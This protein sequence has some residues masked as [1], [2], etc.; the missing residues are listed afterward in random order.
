MATITIPD[1]IC[2][3]CG[4]TKYTI[5]YEKR[6]TISNPDNKRVRYRCVVKA[7]ERN[8]KWRVN[9]PDKVKKYI[10]SKPDG[11]YRTPEMRERYRL[12]AKKESD[13]LA[14]NFIKNKILGKS[15]SLARKNL[16][17]KDIPQELVEIKRQS[18][19]LTRQTRNNGYS[20][21]T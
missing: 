11:Y 10:Q 16:C 6:P 9:H 18:I 21:N 4:G 7:N 12:K 2:T 5:E 17:F 8:H 14:D 20:S 3:H 13:Q 1:K 15:G 19:L